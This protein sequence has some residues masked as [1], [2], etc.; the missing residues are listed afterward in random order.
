M[1]MT[2]NEAQRRLS[3]SWVKFLN[4]CDDD[5]PEKALA[6]KVAKML[7]LGGAKSPKM[8]S[9]L[10]ETEIAALPGYAE[11]DMDAKLLLKLAV[12]VAKATV[13]AKHGVSEGPRPPAP[14]M[15]SL[16]GSGQTAA[17]ATMFQ[18]MG[19]EAPLHVVEAAAQERPDLAK[20]LSVKVDFSTL[21]HQC[22]ADIAVFQ[23]IKAEAEL[24][25]KENRKCF[26]YCE[27][28][29]EQIAPIW[30]QM[31]M[32]GSKSST[33]PGAD[34]AQGCDNA[35]MRMIA[36][37]MQ[38]MTKK[39]RYFVNLTQ[40]SAAFWRYAPV[41]CVYGHFKMGDAIAYHN[42]I[43]AMAER[44][45]VKGELELKAVVYDEVFRKFLGQQCQKG[46]PEI[47]V[48][49]EMREINE[50]L[51]DAVHIRLA[52][53]AMMMPNANA[54]FGVRPSLGLADSSGGTG[55]EATS[56]ALQQ[57]T[58]ISETMRRR[59]EQATKTLLA[60]AKR[61]EQQ[62]AD[63]LKSRAQGGVRLVEGPGAKQLKEWQ[64][65]PETDE[66]GNRLSNTKRR[67]IH[68]L[69]KQDGKRKKAG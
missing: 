31:A 15:G 65:V 10:S 22:Q 40:W 64:A 9:G 2:L 12:S 25:L 48:A 34:D 69:N 49:K 66:K 55:D 6:E 62:I 39:G 67:K 24:A 43:C 56:R 11:L 27:L 16:M 32:I 38:Q 13:T 52:T 1:Q 5:P 54:T 53:V 61:E 17:Q 58:A 3:D 14:P 60:E 41:A 4:I 57:Q 19:S 28:A 21:P 23:S 35:F 45:R 30:M 46:N 63:V 44:A 29:S 33:L 26:C 7:V 8:A 42:L 18:V 37:T 51:E 59:A 68:F 47:D 50:T 36:T 20:A